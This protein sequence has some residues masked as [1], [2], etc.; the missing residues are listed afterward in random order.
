MRHFACGKDKDTEA[1]QLMPSQELTR[2]LVKNQTADIKVTKYNLFS[3]RGLGNGMGELVVWL[4][5]EQIPDLVATHWVVQYLAR[6]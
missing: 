6:G 4:C 1:C 2:K 5:W 3:A